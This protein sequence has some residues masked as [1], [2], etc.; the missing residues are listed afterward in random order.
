MFGA[1]LYMAQNLDT[2]NIGV[3]VLGELRNV[4]LEENEEVLE[5]I[6]K[7]RALLSNI[8]HRKVNWIGHILRRNCL[9]HDPIEGQITEFKGVRRRRRRTAA[10]FQDLKNRRRYWDLKEET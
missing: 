6:G 1:L 7:K 5:H 9:H 10:R 4:V 3:E 8:L 2:N